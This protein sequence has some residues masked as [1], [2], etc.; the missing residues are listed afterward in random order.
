MGETLISR[1]LQQQLMAPQA[2]ILPIAHAPEPP[3]LGSH[4]RGNGT[5]MT[6]TSAHVGT[7]PATITP[8]TPDPALPG[9]TYQPSGWKGRGK[10]AGTSVDAGSGHEHGYEWTQAREGTRTAGE[11]RNGDGNAPPDYCTSIAAGEFRS[12]SL[13]A[14]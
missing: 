6:G 11:A 1:R 5:M 3:H 13:S 9:A 4:D 12:S 2:P 7:G 10:P 8:Y 14:Q